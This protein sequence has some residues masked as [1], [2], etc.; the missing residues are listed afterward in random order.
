LF[1]PQQ[2]AL[3]FLNMRLEP[4]LGTLSSL[5]LGDGTLDIDESDLDP[6][7]GPTDSGGNKQTDS[8]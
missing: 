8:N 6:L 2:I 4:F 7:L 1:L 5:R 3:G